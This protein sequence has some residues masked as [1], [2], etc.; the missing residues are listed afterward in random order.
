MLQYQN[1]VC[2]RCE[3]ECRGCVGTLGNCSGCWEGMA[4][5][6]VTGGEFR[7]GRT[8]CA[9]ENCGYCEVDGVCGNCV[10]GYYLEG[11]ACVL[12]S[13]LLCTAGAVGSKPNQCVASNQSAII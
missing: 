1:S 8:E 10:A 13:S 4:L 7:C 6:V 12:G 5:R 3:G 9:V 2:S 11:N